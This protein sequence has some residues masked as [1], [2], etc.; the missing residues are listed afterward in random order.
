[1]PI[2]IPESIKVVE[3]K[4]IRTLSPQVKTQYYDKV[5]LDI[6]RANAD[7]VTP[8][9]IEEGT[10]FRG[11][12]IRQHL[13]RLTERGEANSIQKGKL[14]LYYPNGEIVGKPFTINSKTKDGRQYVITK[15]EG[16]DGKSFYI[17]QR[18]LD[19]YRSLRVKGGITIDVE[20]IPDF[21]KQ[22]HTHTVRG[23]NNG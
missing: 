4:A 10:G 13:Q 1:M 7:G 15:L 2:V 22:F 14:T 18:E 8:S 20:D 16:R 21:I 19:A 6:L 23:S 5:I 9:E 12:T 17:Q 3:E 11:A